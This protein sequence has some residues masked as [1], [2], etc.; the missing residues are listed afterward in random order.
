[1]NTVS[2]N[3]EVVHSYDGDNVVNNSA[4]ETYFGNEVFSVG[5]NPVF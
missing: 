2:V 3:L 4:A 5:M 1:M